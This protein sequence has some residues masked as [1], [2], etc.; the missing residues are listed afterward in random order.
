MEISSVDTLRRVALTGVIGAETILLDPKNIIIGDYATLSSWTYTALLGSGYV[1]ANS[2]NVAGLNM[3]D[4]FGTAVALNAAGNLL[5]VGAFGDDGMGNATANSGAVHLFSFTGGNFTGGSLQATIGKGYVGGNNI[6][7]ANLESNDYFGSA[8]AF[9]AAG[10]R[11][12]VGAIGD[13][14]AGNVATDAGAAYM[15][16]FSGSNF[17]GGSQQAII[18]KGYAGGKSVDVAGLDVADGFA[19]A[20]ALNATG[21]RLAIGAY[22]DDGA[23]NAAINSGAVY[24]YRFTDNNFTGGTLH[25]TVGKGYIGGNNV[26]VA[27]LESQD[28][29]GISAAFNAVGDRLAVGAFNDDGAGNLALDSGAVY[30]F[31]FAD[32]IFTGGSLQ[33][34]AGKGYVGGNNFDVANLENSDAFGRAVALNAAGTDRCRSRSVNNGAD[35][36]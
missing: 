2:L 36:G 4:N 5:A 9:N 12:A 35:A 20:L 6:D 7:V 11:L 33:A 25:A 24:L 28:R 22:G 8:V 23:G 18:G 1:G 3:Y 15:F 27:N 14:G 31:G 13:D 10:D 32:N 29:F 16:S 17:T 26:N 34:I 30:L 19:S 21:D